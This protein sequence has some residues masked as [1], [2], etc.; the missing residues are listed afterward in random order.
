MAPTVCTQTL[1]TSLLS[2][3]RKAKRSPAAF[4]TTRTCAG[5]PPSE[6]EPSGAVVVSQMTV[7]GGMTS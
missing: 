1:R 3:A 5:S 4:T 2:A 6:N 7:L